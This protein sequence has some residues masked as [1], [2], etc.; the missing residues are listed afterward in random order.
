[1]ARR[2]RDTVENTVQIQHGVFLRNA[3]N[4]GLAGLRPRSA[5]SGAELCFD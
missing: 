5:K 3:Q 4:L 1:M 2:A